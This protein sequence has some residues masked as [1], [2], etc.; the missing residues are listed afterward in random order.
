MQN[1][2]QT[3]RQNLAITRQTEKAAQDLSS[4]ARQMNELMRQYTLN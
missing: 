3:T 1:I 4:L 2:N